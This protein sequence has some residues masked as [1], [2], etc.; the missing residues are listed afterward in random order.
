MWNFDVPGKSSNEIQG[1]GDSQG[2]DCTKTAITVIGLLNKLD[3]LDVVG[4]Y[5]LIIDIHVQN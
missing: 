1:E 5:T 4:M 2:P 3:L